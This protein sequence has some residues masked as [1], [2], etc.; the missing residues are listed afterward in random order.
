[1]LRDKTTGAIHRARIAPL[2]WTVVVEH[3]DGEE[4][5]E[6]PTCSRADYG[7]EIVS[8][9]PE[10]VA[11]MREHGILPAERA[12]PLHRTAYRRWNE[13]IGGWVRCARTTRVATLATAGCQ[14]LRS[15]D[16]G[17]VVRDETP[18]RAPSVSSSGP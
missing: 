10:E 3:G 5:Y 17:A 9:S 14:R 1:M 7:V 16:D 6:V 13:E 15:R 11:S 2:A 4:V 8:A 18:A 12:S